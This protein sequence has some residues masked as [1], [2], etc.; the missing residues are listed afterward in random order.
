MKPAEIYNSE[1]IGWHVIARDG[2]M[3]ARVHP[4]MCLGEEPSGELSFEHTDAVLELYPV[5]DGLSLEAASRRFE[6]IEPQG[7]RVRAIHVLRDTQVELILLDHLLYI[8]NEFVVANPPGETIR[9]AVVPAGEN[10]GRVGLGPMSADR[11]NAPMA[12]G[13]PVASVSG[14]LPDRPRTAIPVD[15]LRREHDVG[16]ANKRYTPVAERPNVLSSVRL[17]VAAAAIIVL[18]VAL[19][20]T[21]VQIGESGSLTPEEVEL[22]SVPQQPATVFPQPVPDDPGLLNPDVLMRFSVL[23]DADVLPNKATIDFTLESLKSLRVAYPSDARVVDALE[24]LT[25][26]L[27]AEARL[28]YDRGDAF[29]AGRLIEQ[30]STTGVSRDSVGVT[31]DYFASTPPPPSVLAS[32]SNSDSEGATTEFVR[33]DSILTDSIEGEGGEAS[34]IEAPSDALVAAAIAEE[35]AEAATDSGDVAPVPDTGAQT[36]RS[37]VETAIQSSIVA[38]AVGASQPELPVVSEILSDEL[39]TESVVTDAIAP[40]AEEPNIGVSIGEREET[41]VDETAPVEETVTDSVDDSL[42]ILL[43]S[44]LGGVEPPSSSPPDRVGPLAP[45]SGANRGMQVFGSTRQAAATS[46]PVL[47]PLSAEAPGPET[48]DDRVQ[49]VL[50]SMLAGLERSTVLADETTETEELME[51]AAKRQQIENNVSGGP[52]LYAFSALIPTFM[53]P[54]EYPRRSLPGADGTIEVEFTVTEQGTVSALDVKGEAP[55]YFIRTAEQTVRRWRFEPVMEDGKAVSVRT[56]LRVQFRSDQ[57][58]RL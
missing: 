36:S 37:V 12:D 24:K 35:I 54:L 19:V 18:A 13:E 15:I 56:V 8:G 27:V 48:V 17:P 26:R 42:R 7:R 14:D 21:Q 28:S 49:M 6:I 38:G 33:T 43:A 45:R 39:T 9:I 41:S 53:I 20:F 55:R 44:L 29:L 16:R 34:F 5:D 32:A 25:L 31:M 46:P 58:G 11:H 50:D 40:V 51:A 1:A 57:T 10:P 30:A 3:T 4:G 52:R 23:L 47:L 2:D 22:T